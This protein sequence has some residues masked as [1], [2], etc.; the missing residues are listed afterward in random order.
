MK[1]R[2]FVMCKPDAVERGLVGEIVG[3]LERKGFVLR[4]AELRSVPRELAE[5]HYDE[6]R[7]KPF[8]GELVD[9]LIRSPVFTM[10]VEGR[11]ENAYALVRKMVGATKVDDAEPGTIRGDYAAVTTENLV[12]ASDGHDSAAREIALWFPGA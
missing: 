9:F 6:H 7:S 10:I 11:D 5:A 4:A 8:F 1:N 12:H 3:R 2:T